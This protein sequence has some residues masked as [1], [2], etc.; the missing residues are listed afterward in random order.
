MYVLPSA[1]TGTFI[2][3]LYDGYPPPTPHPTP[4]PAQFT[5]RTGFG[6]CFLLNGVIHQT[7]EW[8]LA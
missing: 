4:A 1:A 8:C 5:W 2:K 7:C 6:I 3:H